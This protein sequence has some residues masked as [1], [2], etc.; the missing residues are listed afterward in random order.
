MFRYELSMPFTKHVCFDDLLE[1]DRME[2][3]SSVV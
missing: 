3:G 2:K 1:T